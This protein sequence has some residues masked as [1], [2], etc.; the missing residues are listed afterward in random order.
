MTGNNVAI[1]IQD[2][3]ELIRKG[4]FYIDKTAF[5]KVLPFEG[6]RY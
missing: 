4:Y 3:G 6:K 5:I 2:F 1:G